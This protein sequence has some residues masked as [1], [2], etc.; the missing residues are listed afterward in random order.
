MDRE[1]VVYL[2]NR[3]LYVHAKLLQ[4]C[5]TPCNPMDDSPPGSSVHGILQARILEWVAMP[6]VRVFI[7]QDLGLESIRGTQGIQVQVK[8]G[9][10]ICRNACLYIFDKTITQPI[11][12]MKFHQPQQNG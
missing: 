8:Q 6:S 12:R 10:F 2:Q 11:K 9:Y 5:P 3:I 4:L 7:D 1:D